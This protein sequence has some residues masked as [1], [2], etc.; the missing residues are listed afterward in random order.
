VS[1]ARPRLSKEQQQQRELNA[2]RGL[3]QLVEFLMNAARD[4]W[5]D[6]RLWGHGDR[7]RFFGR[8]A[9]LITTVNKL[10][11][12]ISEHSDT[13][14]RADRLIILHDALEAAAIIG[15]CLKT[16]AVGR[17]RAIAA[18]EAKLTDGHRRDEVL[19]EVAKA[20]LRE[21]PTWNRSRVSDKEQTFNKLL[22]A[23]GLRK[24]K[25]PTI[26]KYLGKLWPR[27]SS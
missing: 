8:G 9:D 1:L 2:R 13:G 6:Q 15:G 16:P 26:Y 19:V 4:V 20:I 23:R 27:L 7:A 11:E 10:L 12:A 22:E 21:R 17:F 14:V 25:Q 18:T 24:L 5:Q 3:E